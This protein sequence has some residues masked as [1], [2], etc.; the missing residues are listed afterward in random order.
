[1]KFKNS[2]PHDI[3]NPDL[4]NPN[5]Q[6]SLAYRL[7]FALRLRKLRAID[8]TEKIG[9]GTST[10]SLYMNGKSM[11]SKE[12][13]IKLAKNLRVDPAWLLGLTPLEAYNRYD[14]TDPYLDRD[15]E[16]IK[17]IFNNLNKELPVYYKQ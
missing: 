6:N 11:P 13:V 9:L 7:N 10:M 5:N 15:L 12:R 17:N 3:E 14:D 8:I 1:M 4:R 16:Q 2:K